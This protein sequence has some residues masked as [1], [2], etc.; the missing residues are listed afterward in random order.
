LGAVAG[1]SRRGCWGRV[2]CPPR[3]AGR[4][5]WRRMGLSPLES[6]ARRIEALF[7]TSATAWRA[8]T[9]RAVFHHTR[10]GAA[11]TGQPPDHQRQACGPAPLRRNK[12][13]PTPQ[14]PRYPR[15]PGPLHPPRPWPH[16]EVARVADHV[17]VGKVD[18]HHLVLAAGGF[19]G[20]GHGGEGGRGFPF[21]VWGSHQGALARKGRGR[22]SRRF[23]QTDPPSAR[24]RVALRPRRPAPQISLCTHPPRSPP[25]QKTRACAAP[26]CRPP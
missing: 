13:P 26:P 25:P 9:R 21:R 6:A 5:R 17:R 15:T 8:S 1:G 2:V 20:F 24:A 18:A 19:R 12:R 11:P 7:E 14:T 16:L 4:G 3:P 22:R 10:A 23:K